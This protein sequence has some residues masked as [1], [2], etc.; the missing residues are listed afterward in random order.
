[1]QKGLVDVVFVS[2]DTGFACG[3]KGIDYTFGH[4]VVIKT[5]DGGKSW[6]KV[7]DGGKDNGIVW[8]LQ[9]VNRD[10][11]VGSIQSGGGSDGAFIKS[12]DGGNNWIKVITKGKPNLEDQ[13]IGFI[14]PL[15]GWMGGYYQYMYETTDGGLNW[16]TVKTGQNFNRFFVMDSSHIYAA[17]K[18]I[19]RYGSDFIVGIKQQEPHALVPHVLYPVSPN[20]AKEKIKIE[21]ELGTHTMA[22]LQVFSIDAKRMWEVSRALLTPGHYTYYWDSKDAPPGQYFIRLDNNEMAIIQQFTLIR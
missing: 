16:D 17:G 20:P 14:T 3:Y 13:G 6:S 4:S 2:E 15:K 8:K 12:I 11:A 19:H 18:S 1:L 22:V 5:T 10:F 7:Y 9:F 21:F